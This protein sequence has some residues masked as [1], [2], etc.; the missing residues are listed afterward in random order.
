MGWLLS[1][2]TAARPPLGPTWAAG[3]GW[4]WI[5]CPGEAGADCSAPQLRGRG[6]TV[7]WVAGCRSQDWRQT[8]Q[9]GLGASQVVKAACSCGQDPFQPVTECS[10][11]SRIQFVENASLPWGLRSPRLSAWNTGALACLD[12]RA[13]RDSEGWRERVVCRAGAAQW[14]ECQRQGQSHE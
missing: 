11:C 5:G 3:F 4:S 14:Q 2:L 6:L 7:L 13:Q 1:I 8:D 9:L 10:G 12:G